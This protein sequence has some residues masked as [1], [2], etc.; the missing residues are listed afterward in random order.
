MAASIQKVIEKIVLKMT[1]NI[2]EEY[3]I[4]NLCLAGGVALN[5]V[6]NSKI[7]KQKLFKNIWVQPASGDSGGSLGSALHYI[8]EVKK[9]KRTVLNNK[10]DSMRGSY[11]GNE[12]SDK[13]ILTFLKKRGL[14]I[15]IIIMMIY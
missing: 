6:A 11:L 1:K 15:V 7:L 13:E 4:D 9:L 2:H 12:Y 8:Y 3:K 14:N 10:N 5:C